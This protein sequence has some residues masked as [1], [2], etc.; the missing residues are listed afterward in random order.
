MTKSNEQ[1][2]K[3]NEQRTKSNKQRTKSNK[4]KVTSNEQK[5][6]PRFS[7]IEIFVH[8]RFQQKAISSLL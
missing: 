8:F 2:A 5:A 7:D 3:S 4:Q 6:Q 1:Q